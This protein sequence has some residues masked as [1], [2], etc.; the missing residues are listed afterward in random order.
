MCDPSFNSYKNFR[1]GRYVSDSELK[2]SFRDVVILALA[3]RM[4]AR[5]LGLVTSCMMSPNE[6]DLGLMACQSSS[7]AP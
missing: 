2:H 3:R 5:K 6:G 1:F 7:N 4:S